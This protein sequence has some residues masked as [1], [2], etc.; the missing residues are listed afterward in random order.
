MLP[1]VVYPAEHSSCSIACACRD[2]AFFPLFTAIPGWTDANSRLLHLAVYKHC[3][4]ILYGPLKALSRTGVLLNDPWGV[5][6]L[7]V[8]CLLSYTADQPEITDMSCVIGGNY[9][10]EMCL[11]RGAGWGVSRLG[12]S[13]H[14]CTG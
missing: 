2:V 7:V 12:V 8:P 10:C 4:N 3:L 1:F 9:P 6:Q 11:V 5:P 13:C 14:K